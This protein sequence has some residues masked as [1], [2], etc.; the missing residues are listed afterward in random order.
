MYNAKT[1]SRR[2]FACLGIADLPRQHV[3]KVPLV[4]C[5]CAGAVSQRILHGLVAILYPDMA[6][7]KDLA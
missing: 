2:L 4:A 3:I 1:V 5:F 7:R 6:L